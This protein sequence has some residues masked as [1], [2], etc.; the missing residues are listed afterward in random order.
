MEKSTDG[1]YYKSWNFWILFMLWSPVFFTPILGLYF[2]VEYFSLKIGI[3]AFTFIIILW[4]FMSLSIKNNIR[5]NNFLWILTFFFVNI[6]LIHFVFFK[7][8]ILHSYSTSSFMYLVSLFIY[9][10]TNHYRVYTKSTNPNILEIINPFSDDTNFKEN[11]SALTSI[12]IY[13]GGI[14]L[15]VLT[16]NKIAEDPTIGLFTFTFGMI[17]SIIFWPTV[18]NYYLAYKNKYIH[19]I[20][21][22]NQ[23][24]YP[25]LY[26]KTD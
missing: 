12:I 13:F 16:T 23:K 19:Q 18:L 8:S 17:S 2:G 1:Y 4:T 25:E 22:E 3:I 11:I 15:G 24:K 9:S 6:F 26:A 20:M 21:K 10:K 5:A 14:C 7:K